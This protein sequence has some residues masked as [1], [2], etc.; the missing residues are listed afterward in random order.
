[1]ASAREHVWSFV[2]D[3]PVRILVVDDDPI[4]RE[5]AVVHLSTPVATIETAS[6]GLEAWERLQAASF[7]LA[8]VDIEMPRLDGFGLAERIRADDRLRHLPIVVVTGREDVVSIDRAYAVGATSFVTKPVNWRQLSHQLRYVL[9]TSRV[10]AEARHARERAEEE[11]AI[12]NGMF[13]LM[14]HEFRT[15]LN[16]IIGFSDLIKSRVYGTLGGN[17]CE[18]ASQISEAGHQL[19]GI[20]SEVMNFAHLMSSEAELGEDEYD[21][22]RLVEGALRDARPI[23]DRESVELRCT[24]S[25]ACHLLCDRAQIARMLRHLLHNAV[26]HGASGGIATLTVEIEPSGSLVI[27]VEDQGRG[28]S[29]AQIKSCLEPFR[30]ASSFLTRERGG[31]GLGLPI[32][33]RIVELHGGTLK[34]ASQQ[35]SGTSVTISLPPG[36]LVDPQ[37]Q[38]PAPQADPIQSGLNAAA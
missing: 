28:M 1:M 31:L 21:I 37:L 26:T 16:A 3:E 33:R 14:R 10:E 35:G 20:F 27:A 29:E 8:V 34:I 13:A 18:Y 25:A 2:L 30:Q 32:V 11:T 24:M 6:D 7:D 9:R 22:A 5:F 12:K 17:D 4:L 38:T 36:R 19:L 23:A 15:P